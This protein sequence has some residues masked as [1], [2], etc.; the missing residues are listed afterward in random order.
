[1][2]RAAKTVLKPVAKIRF[3][4]IRDGRVLMSTEH[5]SCIYPNETLLAMQA[6]GYKFRLNGKAF[7]PTQPEKVAAQKPQKKPQSKAPSARTARKKA[8]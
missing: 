8:Q 7:K 4:V 3:E 2:P 6:A 1:M 5:E